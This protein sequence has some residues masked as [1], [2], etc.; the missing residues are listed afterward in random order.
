MLFLAAPRGDGCSAAKQEQG[1]L[2]KENGGIRTK[3]RGK[4]EK[5]SEE[6]DCKYMWHFSYLAEGQGDAYSWESGPKL[7]GVIFPSDTDVHM[8]FNCINPVPGY[9]KPPGV[10]SQ[11]SG[12]KLC[13][14]TAE[15]TF[16]C[17]C[18]VCRIQESSEL[19]F[20]LNNLWF[21]AYKKCSWAVSSIRCPYLVF[22]L[23]LS[24]RIKIDRCIYCFPSKDNKKKQFIKSDYMKNCLMIIISK[25]IAE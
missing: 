10:Q 24:E 11:L 8:L 2:E 13:A 25:P 16:G 14:R 15:F 1:H 4:G 18:S 12:E 3:R 7:V 21:C 23:L 6:G 20:T 5:K 17:L 22:L 9:N 19:Y